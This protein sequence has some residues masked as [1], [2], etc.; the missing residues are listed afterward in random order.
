MG[1]AAMVTRGDPQARTPLPPEW[2]GRS[3]MAE[4]IARLEKAV[5]FRGGVQFRG[6]QFLHAD[7]AGRVTIRPLESG[8]L[9]NWGTWLMYLENVIQESI[10]GIILLEEPMGD[11]NKL[12]LFRGVQPK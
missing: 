11:A 8:T 3:T 6:F 4:R 12:R 9:E 1:D 5:P 10:P 2:W 7:A